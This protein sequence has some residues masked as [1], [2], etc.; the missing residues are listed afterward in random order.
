MMFDTFIARFE[1]AD[2]TIKSSVVLTGVEL[3]CEFH[4][5]TLIL[6]YIW[7]CVLGSLMSSMQVLM[8]CFNKLYDVCDFG[9]ENH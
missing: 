1:A 5:N 9:E 4:L 3:T 8:T 6:L 2:V 7:M